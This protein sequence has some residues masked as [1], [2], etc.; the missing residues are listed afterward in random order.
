MK[1]KEEENNYYKKIGYTRIQITNLT[2]CTN[3]STV[4]LAIF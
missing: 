2:N 4:F 1:E 3:K